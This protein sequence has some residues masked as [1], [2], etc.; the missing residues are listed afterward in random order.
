[1][2]ERV[3]V[4]GGAG[5]IGSHIVDLLIEAGYEVIVIDNLSTGKRENVHPQATFYHVDICD[6]DALERIFAD[7]KPVAVNHQA[8]MADVR[9]SIEAPD[10]YAL[11]NIV[12]TLRLLKAAHR[13][14]VRKVVMASTGG[15][16][17]GEGVKLPAS[18]DQFPHPLDPYGVSKLAGEH[19]LY[20]FRHNF[21]LEYCALRY[22][23]VYGP[24]Q[25]PFGEAGVVAI[26]CGRM[27]R[28]QPVT[29]NGDGKQQRDFIYVG[30][31]AEA[32]LRAIRSGN[33]VYNI[34]TGVGAD[35]NTIFAHLARLT[36]YNLPAHYGPPKAGEVRANM[37][38]ATRAYHDLGWQPTISLEEGLARTVD[39]MR[40]TLPAA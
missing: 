3:I 25:N 35:V 17:Y 9:G 34:G 39:F 32:N 16:I 30:D 14:G 5:F 19:Y 38:D 31:V 33:G 36:G 12:G 6:E 1:M 13:H 10:A 4:T 2:A 18:E 8:A 40:A 37:L 27:L 23:N 20:A 28:S 7:V 21:G 29:I 15:A 22:G 11:V 26:F 24:R